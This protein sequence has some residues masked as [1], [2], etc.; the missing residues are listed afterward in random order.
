MLH[1][2][3]HV[4]KKHNGYIKSTIL[5]KI[6]I[7]RTQHQFKEGTVNQ[8]NQI[9]PHSSKINSIVRAWRLN[10]KRA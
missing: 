4:L 2:K 10:N 5:Q 9:F 7:S 6:S 3:E 1:D 8:A